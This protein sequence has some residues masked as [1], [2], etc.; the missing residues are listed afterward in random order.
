MISI[1]LKPH[2]LLL[3]VLPIDILQEQGSSSTKTRDPEPTK[4]PDLEHRFLEQA[5]HCR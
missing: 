4:T 5:E 2:R 1:K 3:Y